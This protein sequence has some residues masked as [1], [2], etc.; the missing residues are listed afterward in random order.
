MA[1]ESHNDGETP[2]FSFGSMALTEEPNRGIRPQSQLPNE[3]GGEENPDT[4]LNEVVDIMRMVSLNEQFSPE[5]LEYQTHTVDVMR[6]L[7]KQQT[8]LVDE[9]DDAEDRSSFESQIKKLEIDRINYMLRHYFRV[10]IGKIED[11]ILYIFKHNPAYDALSE[12]EK[13]YAVGYSDLIED[14]FKKSF[15]A[16]LPEKLGILEN[17]GNVEHAPPPNLDRFVFCRVRN[18]VGRVAVGE[19]TS[20]DAL[21][22]NQGD[23]LCVRYKSIAKLLHDEDVE[24]M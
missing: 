3:M 19:D 20:S 7:V 5:I 12:A 16:M 22:L 4:S 15:L 1:T 10:R 24:L 6:T 13:K 23:I 2:R 8:D 9:E 21:N 14:H 17:D 18:T 11:S